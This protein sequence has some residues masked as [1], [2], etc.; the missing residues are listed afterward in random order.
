MSDSMVVVQTFSSEVEAQMAKGR[1]ES[2]GIESMVS[3]DD[4]A[5]MHPHLQR[6]YGVKL[7]VFEENLEQAQEILEVDSSA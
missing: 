4:C 7:L 3:S 2:A 1:L 6:A 5:G